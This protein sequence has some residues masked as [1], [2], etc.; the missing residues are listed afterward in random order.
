MAK[1]YFHYGT[2]YSSKSAD[3][4]GSVVNYEVWDRKVLIFTSEKDDR[5]KNLSPNDTKSIVTTRFAQKNGEL[6][7]REA[8]LIERLPFF[9]MIKKQ[10]P[11][12]VFVDEIQFMT[13]EIVL[14]LA[15]VVD[16]LNIPVICY[17]LRSDSNMNMFPASQLLFVI[18]D[19]LIEEKTICTHPGCNKKAIFNL[20]KVNDE[21]VFDGDQITTEKDN[22]SY[23][24]Y[25]R[26][27]Y[28]EY[29]E[30]FFKKQNI[31][32]GELFD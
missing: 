8:Y 18:A 9:E 16:N 7:Y 13:K 30:F 11:E 19:K 32:Q 4:L 17:G 25:C 28:M 12:C 29:R 31:D 2:M 27:H 15:K 22:V 1:L 23:F 3:L 6:F 20:R 10:K 5:A 14:E 21:P 24:P 26:K